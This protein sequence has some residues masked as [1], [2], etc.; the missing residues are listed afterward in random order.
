ME[1]SSDACVRACVPMLRSGYTHRTTGGILVL[2]MMVVKY[3]GLT[4]QL[5]MQ[6][7]EMAAMQRMQRQLA[8]QQAAMAQQLRE[9]QAVAQAAQRA[10][11]QV[12]ASPDS[13]SACR[14]PLLCGWPAQCFA[15][16]LYK[17][18]L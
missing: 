1:A 2:T 8:A 4:R 15:P 17:A 12:C 7:A 18:Q 16:L 10:V 14:A 13:Q 6:S 11:Q 5:G 9:A 3:E